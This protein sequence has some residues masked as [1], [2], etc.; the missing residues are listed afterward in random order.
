[1][2]VATISEIFKELDKIPHACNPNDNLL[3][4]K[5][6]FPL[7]SEIQILYAPRNFDSGIQVSAFPV[8]DISE[9]ENL[10]Q[11]D[12]QGKIDVYAWYKSFHYGEKGWGIYLLRSGIY[13][14]ARMLI[15]EGASQTNS[16]F[17][18]KEFLIRHEKA[19]FQT[20]LG[21][22]SLEIS[23]GQGLYISTLRSLSSRF[24]DWIEIE[25]GLA[26]FLGYKTLK[27]DKSFIENFLNSSPIGYREWAKHKRILE[28]KSWYDILSNFAQ[29]NSVS[30]SPLIA[31]DVSKH[32]SRKYFSQIP[33]FEI[34]DLPTVLG[35]N[36]YLLGA[37]TDIQET[38]EF[39][40]DLSRLSKGRPVY[41]KKWEL[42]KKKLALGNQVGVHFEL[43]DGA[44]SLYSVRID[45]E[46]RV[47]LQRTSGWKAIAAGHHDELYRRLSR[48]KAIDI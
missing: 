48:I 2:S 35:S 5:L 44:K 6:D 38:T 10:E 34:N 42:V 23:C 20:D 7:S 28:N 13:K 37:I 15:S 36:S 40:K 4:A 26:N 11:T 21:V 29:M 25:E 31:A 30:C 18:A 24:P 45:G 14:L 39:K 3:R 8:Y 46:A 17:L 1:M 22:T 12:V 32:L 43:I 41:E 33:I 47:G 27:H 9:V 16:I 19:H